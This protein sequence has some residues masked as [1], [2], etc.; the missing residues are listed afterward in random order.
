[1]VHG[2]DAV[3]VALGQ[4]ESVLSDEEVV[5]VLQVA[6]VGRRVTG[7]GPPIRI[8]ELSRRGL[9]TEIR[10]QGLGEEARHEL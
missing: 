8:Q 2:P 4:R 3:E 7:L 5:D 1:M 6:R 10:R 9:R